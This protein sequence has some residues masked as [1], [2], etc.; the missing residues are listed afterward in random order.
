MKIK[1]T[2]I[3]N[4]KEEGIMGFFK[5]I[6]IKKVVEGMGQTTIDNE[7]VNVVLN[8]IQVVKE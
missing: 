6:V 3:I 7:L 8:D 1:A 5:G 2:V 4:L